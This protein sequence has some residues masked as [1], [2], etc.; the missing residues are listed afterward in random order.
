M[1]H[2]KEL[3]TPSL[4]PSKDDHLSKKTDKILSCSV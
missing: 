1:K 4:P 2:P 3:K